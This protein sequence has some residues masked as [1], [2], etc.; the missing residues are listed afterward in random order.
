MRY[1]PLTKARAPWLVSLSFLAACGGGSTPGAGDSALPVPQA[2]AAALPGA[3][4]ALPPDPAVDCPMFPASA[5]F[6]TRIDDIARFPVHANN[7]AWQELVGRDTPFT[8]N[9]GTSSDP[10]DLDNYWGLPVNVVDAATT[11]WPRVS[12]DYPASGLV[13][14]ASYPAQSDC[15]TSADG[16][17]IVRGCSTVPPAERRFP[18]PEGTPLAE[19]GDCGGPAGCG[20]RHVLVVDRAACRLW[21]AFYAHRIADE[22]YAV[23]TATW[24]LRSHAMRPEGWGSA[25]AAGLPITPLLAK[26]AEASRGEIRHALRVTFRDA[27]LALEHVWPAR[28]AAGADNPGAIPFGALLRLKAD[29]VI[30]ASWSPQARAVALAAQRYGLYVA[31]NGADFHVQGSPDSAWDPAVW[32]QLRGITLADTEFVDTGAI[33]RD[34]RFSADSL[35]ASW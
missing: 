8:A 3:A 28:F 5:I 6:N 16:T 24:D 9:W 30:P 15:A 17:S 18:F 19:G 32:Q 27:A 29:F 26:A 20:D 12:F 2:A 1:G 4:A 33:T 21:E 14:E 7:A 13:F 23:A 34:P 25:D 22:W 35:R 31:D 11:R 10:R